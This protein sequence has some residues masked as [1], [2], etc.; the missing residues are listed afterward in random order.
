M[1]KW[2]LKKAWSHGSPETYRNVGVEAK[3]GSRRENEGESPV[4]K[5]AKKRRRQIDVVTKNP[6]QKKPGKWR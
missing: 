4:Y 6:L 1:R 5:S 2:M 3:A